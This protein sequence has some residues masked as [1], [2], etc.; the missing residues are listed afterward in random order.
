LTTLAA[1]ITAFG[2]SLVDDANAAAARTTLGVPNIAGDTFTGAVAVPDD[3]YDSTTWNGSAQVPTKNAVRDKIEA[4]ILGGGSYTDEQAQDAI[5]VMVADTA[6]VDVTYTDATPEL[7]WDVKDDSISYAKMQNVSAVSK[8]LGRGSAAGAGDPE[9]ITLGTNLSMSGTTLNAAGGGGVADGDKGDVTVSSSG[10]VWTVDNDVIT[11]AKMQNVSATDKL[12]GRVTAGAGDVEE[13]AC[14]AA[15]RAL[16]DD[17]NAAAQLATL[18][19]DADIA[20]LALPAS[21]TISA[22]GASLVD[23]AN[24]AAALGTLGAAAASHVH[25]AADITS[26]LLANGRIATGT[27]DGTKFLRDDQVWATP[28]GSGSGDVVGPASSVDAEIPIFSGTTGKL[29]KRVT[30]TASAGTWPKLPSGTLLT[31]PEAGATEYNGANKFFTP[32]T[33]SGRADDVAEHVFK[34][35]A[36]L[37]AIGPT[38]ADFFGANSAFPFVLN[39]DYEFEFWLVFLKT[40]AGT[41]IWTLTNTQAYTNLSA[42]LDTDA[43]TGSA[44]GA[45]SAIAPNAINRATMSKWTTAAAAFGASGSLTTN[46]QHI[47]RIAARAMCGTAGN[48]RLRATLSAGTVTPLAGSFYKVRRLPANTGAFVA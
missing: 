41:V 27:P 9:E 44:A 20:T 22:F 32:N 48:I 17:A 8:L 3:A 39:G 6:T 36:D 12:L 4:L 16:I 18:G 24:A 31:T 38:I 23:D 45:N 42:V 13:I 35:D 7:K 33:T 30:G 29:L 2:H 40:T 21:T 43:A 5:G 26:G 10:A 14:T 46:T 1:N 47:H 28:A 34:L 37:A 15:G 19:L 25:A 11:Y